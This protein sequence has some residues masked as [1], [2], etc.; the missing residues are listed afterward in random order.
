MEE[1]ACT[2][3]AK[4]RYRISSFSF[5]PFVCDTK[6]S[7]ENGTKVT[8]YN[9]ILP[10]LHIPMFTTNFDGWNGL[11][12]S[13][14]RSCF[15]IGRYMSYPFPNGK[16]QKWIQLKSKLIQTNPMWSLNYKQSLVTL[17]HEGHDYVQYPVNDI[18]YILLHA[19][20]DDMVTVQTWVNYLFINLQ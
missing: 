2:S 16:R 12:L 18:S 4:V 15:W 20:S 7:C 17:E 8:I 1:H 19:T 9:L 6:R 13:S 11:H 5:V 10:M 3:M 14:L